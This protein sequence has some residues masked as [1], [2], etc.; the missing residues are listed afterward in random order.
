MTF[1]VILKLSMQ[2]RAGL[3]TATDSGPAQSPRVYVNIDPSRTPVPSWAAWAE[4]PSP[5]E[6][7]LQVRQKARGHSG[8]SKPDLC[9]E[10]LGW[11]RR[12]AWNQHNRRASTLISNFRGSS[13]LRP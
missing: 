13:Y 8:F 1:R 7:V 12:L 6:R 10:W 9:K 4:I 5:M 3:D 2:A 11:I